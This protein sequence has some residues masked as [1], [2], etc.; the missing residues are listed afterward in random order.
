M[1]FRSKSDVVAGAGVV[2]VTLAVAAGFVSVVTVPLTA[3][4]R[5]A[6]TFALAFIVG[7]VL[8]PTPA[9]SDVH[10]CMFPAATKG[11]LRCSVSRGLAGVALLVVVV[12][13]RAV[14]FI[15]CPVVVDAGVFMPAL[16]DDTSRSIASLISFCAGLMCSVWSSAASFWFASV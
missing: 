4:P 15:G 9:S 5:A 10:G 16:R 2:V 3:P 11:L 14:P 7:F 8:S 12:V 6:C 1:Y 13:I